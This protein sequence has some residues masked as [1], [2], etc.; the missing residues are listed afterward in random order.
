MTNDLLIALLEKAKERGKLSD[1]Q[2]TRYVEYITN[3]SVQHVGIE[4]DGI[5]LI[6]D[7]G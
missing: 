4:V 6:M 1:L 5:V 3:L 7:N 2:I